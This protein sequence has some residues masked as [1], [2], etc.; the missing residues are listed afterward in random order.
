MLFCE[1]GRSPQQQTKSGTSGV[2]VVTAISNYKA[3][4][5]LSLPLSLSLSHSP[6]SMTKMN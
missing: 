1:G 6:F 4:S 5:S 3:T 2:V